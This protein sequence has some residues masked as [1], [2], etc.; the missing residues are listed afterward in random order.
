MSL[1]NHTIDAGRGTARDV[2]K[3]QG[4][5]NMARSAWWFG[6]RGVALGWA[7]G[8]GGGGVVLFV[9]GVVGER[10]VC[11]VSTFDTRWLRAVLVGGVVLDV[12]EDS[13]YGLYGRCCW[14]D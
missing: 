9:D 5:W 14:R 6:E 11:F 12:R 2:V 3:W 10:I 4:C 8:D 1:H 13:L 7:Y